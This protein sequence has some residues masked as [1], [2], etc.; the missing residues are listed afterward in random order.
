MVFKTDCKAVVDVFHSH[1]I[2]QYE[3]EYLCKTL[4]YLNVNL[5]FCFIKR[6]VNKVTHIVVRVVCYN[7]SPFYWLK[8]PH[9]IVE[10]LIID[11][12]SC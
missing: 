11:C 7:I 1:I 4:F 3:F 6:Q 8:V 2:N 5:S 9:F 12:F 10:V